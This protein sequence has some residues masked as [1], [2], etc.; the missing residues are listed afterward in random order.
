[1]AYTPSLEQAIAG[2]TRSG[3]AGIR[4]H[5]AIAVS[6]VPE[7]DWEAAFADF[8]RAI[9][10]FREIEARPDLARALHHYAMALDA[11]GKPEGVTVLAEASALFEELGMT[12]D[13]VPA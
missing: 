2:R 12:Q 9:E 6:S 13:P 1:D 4:L 10:L 8:D 7:P 5:R 3:E 11:A